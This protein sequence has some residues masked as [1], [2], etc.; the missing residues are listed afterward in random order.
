MR[1]LIFY[2]ILTG[3][4]LFSVNNGNL[5]NRDTKASSLNAGFHYVA[6]DGTV[7][8]IAAHPATVR[9]APVVARHASAHPATGTHSA[10]DANPAPA[11]MLSAA[12]RSEAKS[13]HVE[14][15]Q[16]PPMGKPLYGLH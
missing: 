3:F 12:E 5:E 7:T 13:K 4:F 1:L 2:L 16:K 9:S 14:A 11:V 6:Q 15:F 10:P 8:A